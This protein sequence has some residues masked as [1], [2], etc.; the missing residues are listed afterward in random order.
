M[1]CFHCGSPT[2]PS[3]SGP[4]GFGSAGFGS[5]GSGALAGSGYWYGCGL[6][7]GLGPEVRRCS[8]WCG[9]GECAAG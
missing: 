2:A 5:A 4:T 6:A 8:G 1:H 3:G 9:A 7:G